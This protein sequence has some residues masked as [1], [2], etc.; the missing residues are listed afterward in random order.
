MDFFYDFL[1]LI[2]RILNVPK[3]F[4]LKVPL[5]EERLNILE[6]HKELLEFFVII[7]LDGAYFFPHGGQLVDLCFD[8]LVEL[9]DFVLQIIYLELIE[10]HD[11]MVPVLPQ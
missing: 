9:S 1:L 11:L 3:C 8:F 2:F 7:L 6:L 4:L 10:H 5:K